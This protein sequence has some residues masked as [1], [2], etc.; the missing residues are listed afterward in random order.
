MKMCIARES[1][2]GTV[3][4]YLNIGEKETFLG[5][6]QAFSAGVRVKKGRV[7][8]ACRLN[9]TKVEQKVPKT[10]DAPEFSAILDVI[11]QT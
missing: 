2:F 6:K 9:H 7:E 3:S 4:P 10:V 5:E 11:V 1:A 8:S